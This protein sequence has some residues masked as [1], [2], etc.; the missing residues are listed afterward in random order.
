MIILHDDVHIAT[1]VITP[2]KVGIVGRPEP[3]PN[4]F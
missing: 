3:G 1:P 2:P 4:L